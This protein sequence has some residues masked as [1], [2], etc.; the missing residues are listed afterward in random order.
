MTL[1]PEARPSLSSFAAS[2]SKPRWAGDSS[3]AAGKG[4]VE[5]KRGSQS[6]SQGSGCY[7]ASAA[8]VHLRLLWE[9][10]LCQGRLFGGLP[11]TSMKHQGLGLS[12]GLEA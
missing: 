8:R 1:R 12:L 6:S 3:G 5:E 10:E 4:Q 9:E 7:T 2:S 11:C